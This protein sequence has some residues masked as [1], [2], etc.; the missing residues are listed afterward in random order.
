M[1]EKPALLNIK[2]RQN[3]TCL[4]CDNFLEEVQQCIWHI[5]RIH[6]LEKPVKNW[7]YQIIGHSEIKEE[8]THA[9]QEVKI[10]KVA[11]KV[12]AKEN[13]EIISQI[14]I[15]LINTIP[16]RAEILKRREI[17]EAEAKN[18]EFLLNVHPEIPKV[19]RYRKKYEK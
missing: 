12:M 10:S 14:L 11:T 18:S 17:F 9:L 6:F 16:L 8:A 7:H 4:I 13:K 3:A 2:I 5:K 15:R 19:I 1:S